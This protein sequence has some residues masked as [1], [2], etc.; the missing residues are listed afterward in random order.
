MQS[1]S[2]Q[3]DG[4]INKSQLVNFWAEFNRIFFAKKISGVHVNRILLQDLNLIWF[5]EYI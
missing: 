1:V 4:A 3:V 2:N 5:T